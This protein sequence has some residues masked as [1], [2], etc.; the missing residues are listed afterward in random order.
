MAGRLRSA[1]NVMGGATQ[2]DSVKVVGAY[3]RPADGSMEFLVGV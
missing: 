1:D 3:F 2:K